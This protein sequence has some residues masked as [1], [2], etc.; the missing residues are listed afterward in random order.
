[1]AYCAGKRPV[2]DC[3]VADITGDFIIDQA[4]VDDFL[5]T[6]PLL[7]V[8][9]DGIVFF[10]TG[11]GNSTT[12]E[13]L[14]TRQELLITD[15]IGKPAQG[16]CNPADINGDGVIDTND[17]S[18]LTSAGDPLFS[19]G[20][21]IGSCIGKPV[22]GECAAA[23]VNGDGAIDTEDLMVFSERTAGN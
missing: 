6:V 9:R 16:E 5:A 13:D 7:D 4:D 2:E 21:L 12:P 8:N 22:K 14:R 20:Q 19:E 11:G 3:I 1:M 10:S 18:A 23:D 15:C 17:L